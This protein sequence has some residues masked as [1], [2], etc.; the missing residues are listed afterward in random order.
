[1]A[2]RSKQKSCFPCVEAKRRCDKTRPT[3]SRCAEREVDCAYPPAARVRQRPQAEVDGLAADPDVGFKD[4]WAFSMVD[5]GSGSI[6]QVGGPSDKALLDSVFATTSPSLQPAPSSSAEADNPVAGHITPLCGDLDWFLRPQAWTVDY[7]YQAPDTLPPP[8]V[9]SNFIRGLQDWISRFVSN[10]HSPFIHRH[11]Y[12]ETGLPQCMQD[13]YSAV[14]IS[15]TATP[16]NE[17]MVDEISSA[18]ISNLLDNQT[19]QGPISLALFSTRDHLARTQ[20][21]LIHLLLA[22][23]SSSIAR[24]ARAEGLVGTLRNWTNQLWES[25]TQDAAFAPPFPNVP[26]ALG[27]IS[28]GD[29][30]PVPELYRAFILSESTRRT[31]LLCNIATGVYNSLKGE[32]AEAC[33]GDIHITTHADL[34]DAPSSARWEAIARHTD[35]LFVYSLRGKTLMERGV[36]AAE[37]DEFARHLFTVMWGLEKVETWVVRTGDA[38]SVTY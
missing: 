7:H 33:A 29:V 13:A 31:W 14:A 2:S 38:V 15:K 25:A 35:P 27:E 26:P 36:R 34:W 1:M 12:S 6:S 22:L 8:S 19:A 28:V 30:D 5:G 37:V 16:E 3:C 32:W 20:A 10:G 9:F 17:H 24:R 4:V 21:L 11:L 23:F 18:H